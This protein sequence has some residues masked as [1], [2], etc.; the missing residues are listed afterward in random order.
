[1]ST[2]AN[3]AR[4]GAFVLG[5]LSLLIL[6]ILALGGKKFFSDNADYVLYFDGSVSGLS[7]GA[8]V[9]F[10]GVP[11]GNVTKITLVANSRDEGV[12]IPV[13]ISIAES[14]IV[15]I[16]TEGEISDAMREE[17]IRRMVRRGLRA[18]LQMQSFI[19]GQ[20]RV[21]LDFF[22]GTP[23]RYH[24]SNHEQEIPTVPS[25]L[26]EFQKTLVRLPLE[27]IANSLQS[28]LEGVATLANSEDLKQAIVDLKG[29]LASAHVMFKGMESLPTDA[30]GTFEKLNN[31]AGTVDK[32]LPD[33]IFAFQLAM[34]SFAA[35][36]AQ[37][38]DTLLT[39]KNLLGNDSR[40]VRDLNQALKEFNATARAVRELANMLER[41]PEALLRGKGQSR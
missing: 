19:T 30:K 41:S 3:K 39:A 17:I 12:T 11:M 33:A 5:G 18:R 35:A 10:R 21:E 26:D 7:I 31:A 2:D 22:P 6:G 23:A 38:E 15:R 9:V 1:M 8:P 14:N 40:T 13:Y 28:A 29:T 20:Y 24:T 36:G 25:P 34:K 37:M 32:Q 16:G 4:I 27:S